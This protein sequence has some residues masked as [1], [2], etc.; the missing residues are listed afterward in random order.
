MTSVPAELGMSVS[1]TSHFF[2]PV[3]GLMAMKE[4]TTSPGL[5][6]G[7]RPTTPVESAPK[8]CGFGGAIF[9][10]RGWIQVLV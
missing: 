4:P 3:T 6:T 9:W 1:G 2:S 7:L 8:T 10:I 5:T